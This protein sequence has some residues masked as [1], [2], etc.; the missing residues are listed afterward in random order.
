MSRI[1]RSITDKAHSFAATCCHVFK[2]ERNW[3][4]ES[5]ARYD[6]ETP[7]HKASMIEPQNFTAW[8]PMLTQPP[9]SPTAREIISLLM[10]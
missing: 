3:R 7:C 8:R 1:L 10:N 6:L 9:P 4:S 2:L 5:D